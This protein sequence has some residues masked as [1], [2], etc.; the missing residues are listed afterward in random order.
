MTYLLDTNACSDLMREHPAFDARLAALPQTDKI[1]TCPIVRGE[2]L[3]GIGRLPPGTR[4]RELQAKADAIFAAIPCEPLLAAA[5]DCYAAVKLARFSKGLALDENDVWVA[6]CA[7][8]AQATL[9]TRDSDFRQIDGL[10][11]DDWTK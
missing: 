7:V 8:A 1:I 5:G 9:V 4:R 11:V 6:A 2:I 3:F 10:T